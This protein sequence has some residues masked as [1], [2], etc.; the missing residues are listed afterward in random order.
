MLVVKGFF[1]CGEDHRVNT[2]HSRNEVTAADNK[3]K[4][5]HPTSLLTFEDLAAVVEMVHGSDDA[6]ESEEDEDGVQWIEK[7]EDD[8]YFAFIS[9]EDAI[10]LEKSLAN[11]AFVHDR[12]H[13]TDLGSVIQSMNSYLRQK[14]GPDFG[15]IRLD[16]CAN[17]SSLFGKPKYEAYTRE[18]GLKMRIHPEISRA[19]R[20][21][22]GRRQAIVTVRIQIPFSDLGIIIDVDFVI[23][24]ENVPTMLS[25]KEWY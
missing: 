13:P 10:Y 14:C 1:V 11:S 21:I 17:L 2:K 16:T 9:T 15:G 19:I 7:E 4:S 3:L 23:I 6:P 25:M 24:V 20:G 8:S 22:G 5:K 18:V 12:S